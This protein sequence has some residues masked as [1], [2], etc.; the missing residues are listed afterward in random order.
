MGYDVIVTEGVI[1]RYSELTETDY[2][3]HSACLWWTRLAQVAYVTC[4]SWTLF[5]WYLLLTLATR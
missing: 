1:A 5:A 3:Y 4:W 2:A